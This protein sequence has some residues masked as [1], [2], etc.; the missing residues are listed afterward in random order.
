MSIADDMRKLT[1]EIISSYEERISVVGTIIDDTHRVLDDFR[2]QRN[3]MSAQLKDK[4]SKE[5]TLRKKDFD[6]MMADITAAQEVRE[7]ELRDSLK[8]YLEE[9]KNAVGTIRSK[10]KEHSSAKNEDGQSVSGN[11][12]TTLDDI[13]ARQRKR[14][15]EVC[16]LLNEFREEHK[17]TAQAMRELLRKGEEIRVHDLKLMLKN[18]RDQ[19]LKNKNEIKQMS[20]HWAEMSQAM[21]EKR[22]ARMQSFKPTGIPAL[23]DLVLNQH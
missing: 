20:S 2:L 22:L 9:Q 15:D 6:A 10:L 18:I 14:Q 7:Q 16:N 11:F 3:E 19:R 13:Q 1:E 17:A 5:K 21:E 8:S 12:K 23:N 4:L